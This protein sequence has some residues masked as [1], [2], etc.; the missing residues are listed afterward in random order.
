MIMGCYLDWDNDIEN[1]SHSKKKGTVCWHITADCF[2]KSFIS[3]PIYPA[4]FAK[5]AFREQDCW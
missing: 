1:K 5:I 3:R 4:L 2:L